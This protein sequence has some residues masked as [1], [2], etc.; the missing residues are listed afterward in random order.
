MFDSA[1]SF[2][3]EMIK[4]RE[5][6]LENLSSLKEKELQVRTLNSQR[7][8][9]GDRSYSKQSIKQYKRKKNGS[10]KERNFHNQ[11]LI[12]GKMGRFLAPMKLGLTPLKS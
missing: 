12:V 3:H 1:T 4:A 2:R 10:V 5:E 6:K 8:A 11:K 9:E 7:V